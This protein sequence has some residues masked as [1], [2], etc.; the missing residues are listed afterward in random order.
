MLRKLLFCIVAL[1]SL[2]VFAQS[3]VAGKSFE[4]EMEQEQLSCFIE[5]INSDDYYIEV[6]SQETDDIVYVVVLSYG[7][8]KIEDGRVVLTD[9]LHDYQMEMVLADESLLIQKGFGFM[10]GKCFMFPGASYRTDIPGG[11]DEDIN[12]AD[13]QE[14]RDRYNVQNK[15]LHNLTYG[16]YKAIKF[17]FYLDVDE[18]NTYCFGFRDCP[19]SKG[20]FKRDGNVLNLY[21]PSLDC[22]FYLLIGDDNKLI[23]K[24]LPGSNGSVF[25][26]ISIP[27]SKQPQ[28]GGSGCSRKKY[29]F[30]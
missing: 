20:T 28:K 21:D 8:Y 15:E 18:N 13:I 24:S 26:K 12:K 17:A 25:K 29:S 4:M 1:A 7:K 10:K 27:S 5:F 6:S 9:A 16:R 30:Q 11:I 3:S 23:S 22:T 19:F 2:H 14:E